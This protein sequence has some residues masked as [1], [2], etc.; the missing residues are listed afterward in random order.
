MKDLFKTHPFIPSRNPK[1]DMNRSKLLSAVVICTF[2][3]QLFS[4]FA[5]VTAQPP[6]L[7]AEIRRGPATGTLPLSFHHVGTFGE[8]GIPYPSDGQ[9]NRLNSP[10]GIILDG[11]DNVYLA[12]NG[13]KRLWSL[14]ASGDTIAGF[15]VGVAGQNTTLG[16]PVD[17]ALYN[18]RL[19]VADWNRLVVYSAGGTTR[20]EIYDFQNPEP[21]QPNWFDCAQGLTFDAAGR[22]YV[23]QTCGSNNVLLLTISGSFPVY[24]LTLSRTIG[25]GS[26]NNPQQ[27]IH[28]DLTGSSAALFVSDDNGLKRCTEDSGTGDWACPE[29][30]S[31]F[32]GRG[33]GLNPT[34]HAH[35]YLVYA[36]WNGQGVLRCDDFSCVDYIVNLNESPQVLYDPVDVAFDTD[37]TA[38]VTDRGDAAVKTFSASDLTH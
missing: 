18:G 32:Q 21:N 4:P 38:F 37:G 6:A 35:L 13:G 12:E 16:N 27:A 30:A 10:G 9:E 24:Q 33:V 1:E 22:L 11:S 28:T 36:G 34:D 3:V 19:W 2:L 26:L 31:G 29:I 5:S 20:Q 8:T 14:T 15:P 23:V 17:V 7:R 25:Q